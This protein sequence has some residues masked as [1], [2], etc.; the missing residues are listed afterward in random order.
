MQK[1]NIGDKVIFKMN[2]GSDKCEELWSGIISKIYN[3]FYKIMKDGVIVPEVTRK[4]LHFTHPEIDLNFFQDALIS[5]YIDKEG[6]DEKRMVW[7][8]PEIHIARNMQIQILQRQIDEEINQFDDN[9]FAKFQIGEQVEYID[10]SE[11]FPSGACGG[12]IRFSGTIINI[13]RVN[14]QVTVRTNDS[15]MNRYGN[16]RYLNKI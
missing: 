4:N 8:K 11:N 9:L 1:Y 10:D 6:D 5:P 14:M 12:I 2:Y 13:E 16:I 3:N 15:I 7:R